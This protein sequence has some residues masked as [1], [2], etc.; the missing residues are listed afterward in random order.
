[1]AIRRSNEVVMMHPVRRFVVATI[2]LV[3]VAS[4]IPSTSF[5][6]NGN[7]RARRNAI[8]A[9]RPYLPVATNVT[10]TRG[11]ANPADVQAVTQA[12]RLL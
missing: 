8:M 11:Q 5:A 9:N 2:A 6:Q 10:G 4:M 12:Y 3:T 7:R 1:L